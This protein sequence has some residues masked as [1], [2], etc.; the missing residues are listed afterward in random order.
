MLMYARVE[1]LKMTFVK[2]LTSKVIL[3]NPFMAL[4]Y[5]FQTSVEGISTE[6]LGQRVLFKYIVAPIKE[7]NQLKGMSNF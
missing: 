6:I 4:I 1:C 2:D 7:V 5:P 3:G